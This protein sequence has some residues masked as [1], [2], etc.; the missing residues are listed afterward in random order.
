M[1]ARRRRPAWHLLIEDHF[2]RRWPLHP[3]ADVRRLVLRYGTRKVL[4]ARWG[5]WR[6]TSCA[7]VARYGV[8][9]PLCMSPF[10]HP[11]PTIQ[12][13]SATASTR[14][15]CSPSRHVSNASFRNFTSTRIPIISFTNT[16]ASFKSAA[17]CSVS[18]CS[19]TCSPVI[20]SR[21]GT[22]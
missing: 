7:M 12:Q 13:A 22:R 8:R 21:F 4:V 14:S 2:D 19:K 9:P 10:P 17:I 20:K 15:S 3:G 5:S 11:F 18:V 6:P 16:A 1:V